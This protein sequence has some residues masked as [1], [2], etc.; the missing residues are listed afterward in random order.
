VCRMVRVSWVKTWPMD[1][2]NRSGDAQ[3][4]ARNSWYS[5]GSGYVPPVTTK[6]RPLRII[7]VDVSQ[8]GDR[9]E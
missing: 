1:T 6:T 9:G 5:H 7:T 2:T 4:K 8:V 3:I